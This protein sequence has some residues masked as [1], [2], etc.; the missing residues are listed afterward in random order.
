V[1]AP[2][3]ARPPLSA[4]AADDRLAQAARPLDGAL[5]RPLRR[6]LH[7]PDRQRGRVGADVA[8][9]RGPRDL[10][11][12]P[13]AAA[14]R[15]GEPDPAPVPRARLGPPARRLAAPAPAQADAAL[16]PRRPHAPLRVAD[17]RRRRAR[18][19]DV[20]RG[21]PARA[22]APHA[23]AD[24]GDHPA[25]GVRHPRGRAARAHA[26]RAHADARVRHPP[27]LVRADGLA[28]PGEVR[29]AADV[30]QG[31]R[32][33]RRA[34]ARRDPHA[35]RG[36]RP[37][38]AGRHHVAAAAGHAR[39]RLADGRLRA[40]RRADHAAAGRPRD[41]GDLAVVGARA[42]AAPPRRLGPA[43]RRGGERRDDLHR[44]DGQGDAAPAPG[45]PARRPRAPAADGDRRPPPPRRRARR[46]LHLPD[47][48]PPRALP[49]ARGVPARALPRPH[50][51]D[52]HVDPLRRRHPALPRRELRAVRDEH[53]ARRRRAL[54]EPPGHAPRS[55][56]ARPAPGDHAHPRARRRGGP[57]AGPGL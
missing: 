31:H 5:P 53:G 52:V 23:G 46:A 2:G 36:G 57:R 19:R 11:G 37:G 39:G 4:P 8:P 20:A 28:R 51:G 7:H 42:P 43:A 35:P 56:R 40:A 10:H 33:G 47:A 1:D 9:G 32:P 15:Q 48:P 45:A 21:R 29:R 12:R 16:L 14:R 30:P 41:D 3:T 17:G 34:A 50:A 55:Q 54:R 44:R 27:E 22:D 13:G 25:R 26:G 6:H 49:R 38:R 18:G 24:H